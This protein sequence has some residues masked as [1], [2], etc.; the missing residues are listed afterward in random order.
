MVKS[1]WP[2]L[3]GGLLALVLG[4]LWTLQ[5]LDLLSGSSMSGATMWA[6]IGPIVAIAGLAL[7]IVGFRKRGNTKS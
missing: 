7:I 4:V 1:G 2:W 3:T 6:V 5:G